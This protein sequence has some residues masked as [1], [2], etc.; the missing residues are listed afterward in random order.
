MAEIESVGVVAVVRAG[1]GT[2]LINIAGAL[3]RGGVT[4]CEITMTTP[5]AL[6]GIAEVSQALGSSSLVGVGS[7][8]D[9]ETARMAILAGAQFVV[10]P[11][12]DPAIIQMAHRYDRPAIVG[13]L[14]PTE[15][16]AAWTAGA[17]A[18]KVF[19]ANHFGP[20]YFRDLH[21]PMPQLKLTPTG[22]VDI[23]TIGD[24]IAAG[25]F[26]VG[27]GTALVRKD[28]LST[29]DWEGLAAL[30]SGYVSAV[31]AARRP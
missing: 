9:P 15:I 24:W 8:L 16:L 27:A 3:A 25:A 10:S 26:A 19:P 28:L 13:A 30:A 17:D 1:S 29:G 14:T 2:S 31:Q 12:F 21:G 20:Q 22:G 5:G 6:E 23:S 11:T 18:V 4:A 7:V